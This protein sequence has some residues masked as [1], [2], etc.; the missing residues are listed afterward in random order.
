M[1]VVLDTDVIVAALRSPEGASA[2]LLEFAAD[3][4][5]VPLVSVGL[6]LEYEVVC[7]RDDHRR[8]SGLK[9]NEVD[10]F[11][12]DLLALCRPVIADFRWRPQL[13]DADDE[14]VIETAINGGAVAIVTFNVRDFATAP[15]RFGIDVL[16]PADFLRSIRR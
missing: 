2:R 9:R 12:R 13:A 3:G 6:A 11:L 10:L 14:M 1:R 16:R 7:Q 15:A 8:A 4:L 5:L